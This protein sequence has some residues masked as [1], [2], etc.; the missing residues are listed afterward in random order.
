MQAAALLLSKSIGLLNYFNLSIN[1]TNL[2]KYLY[3][4]K[5]SQ[6]ICVGPAAKHLRG[7]G[8]RGLVDN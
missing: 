3:Q 1:Y 8:P 2:I 6:R 4:Y 7:Q 5:E